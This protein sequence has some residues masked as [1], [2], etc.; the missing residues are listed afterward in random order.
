MKNDHSDDLLH[1]SGCDECRQ[2]FVAD[3]VVSFSGDP[4]S[5]ATR[6]RELFDTARRLREEK[7]S[8]AGVVA[9][10]LRATPPDDWPRLADVPELRNSA[11]LEQMSEEVRRLLDREPREALSLSNL[12]TDIAESLPPGIYPDTV[13]AQLRA[14]AWKDRANALRYLARYPEAIE[15]INTAEERLEPHA[16]L[17]YDRAVVRLVKAMVAH[18]VGQPEAA[19]ALLRHCRTVF[20]DFGDDTRANMAG[21]IEANFLYDSERYAEARAV[22]SALLNTGAADL[23][24]EAGLH[25]NLGYCATHVGDFVSANIH[26]SEAIARFT[27]LGQHAAALRTQRGAGVLL[28]SKGQVRSAIEHLSEVRRRYLE[29]EMVEEA[30]L[31]GLDMIEALVTR[32][33]ISE[34]SALVGDIRTEF[35]AAHLSELAITALARL[36]DAI[37]AGDADA[38]LAVRNVSSFIKSLQQRATSAPA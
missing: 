8:A 29:F 16:A 19:Y 35:Q 24:A 31:C 20:G 21:M 34:A 18:Q 11:A 26:F 32:G 10:Y 30:G 36:S 14:T 3:N 6:R 1:L 22:F 37:A 27:E 2:R 4:T 25:S 7:E 13:V 9:R 12:A 23:E 15:A 33:D 28:L 5:R 17:A 38:T